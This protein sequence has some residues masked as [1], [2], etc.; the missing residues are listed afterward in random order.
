MP[1]ALKKLAAAA[2][3]IGS[4]PVARERVAALLPMA[5]PEGKPDWYGEACEKQQLDVCMVTAAKLVNE[6]SK[7]SDP[8]PQDP[9]KISKKE[10]HEGL[11]DSL[12]NPVA[13]S[14]GG[15]QRVN[16]VQL[17]VYLGVVEGPAKAGHHHTGL[18]FYQQKRRFF[19]GHLGAP[20]A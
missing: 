7:T 10:F 6:E 17:D 2:A 12:A 9:A 3:S 4:P 19:L 11:M 14:K 15:R 8:P 18:K 1:T 13:I 16:D 20:E 5:E